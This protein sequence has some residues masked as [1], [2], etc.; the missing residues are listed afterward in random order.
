[1]IETRI[2][3]FLADECFV[4]IDH[5]HRDDRLFP[6]LLDSLDLLRLVEFVET[7]FG[8]V[9]TGAEITL[10]HFRTVATLCE[11][12]TGRGQAGD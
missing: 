8:I 5:L 9:M 6:D 3:T 10:E 4:E 7:E 12:V 2:R 1:M 11:L